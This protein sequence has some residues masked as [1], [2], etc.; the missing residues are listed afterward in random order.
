MGVWMLISNSK[1]APQTTNHA[2]NI[3]V[4]VGVSSSTLVENTKSCN[5]KDMPIYEDNLGDLPV[6]AIKSNEPKT[7]N[8][9]KEESKDEKQI[10]DVDSKVD[11]ES[12]P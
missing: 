10:D 2:T 5:K 8:D 1:V 11:Q 7:N 4:D 6:D 12:S 9:N 3:A